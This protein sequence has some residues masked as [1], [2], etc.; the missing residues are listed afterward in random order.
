MDKGP[1][2]CLNHWQFAADN[3]HGVY[4]CFICQ[5][6]ITVNVQKP[7]FEERSVLFR[8]VLTFTATYSNLICSFL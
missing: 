1:D 7:D 3:K 4:I 6:V 2:V 5:H 8:V